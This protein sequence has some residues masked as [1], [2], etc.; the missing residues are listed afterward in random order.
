MITYWHLYLMASIYVL[1]GLNHFRSPKIYIKIMPPYL[2]FP[3]FLNALSGLVEIIFGVGL[4]FLQTQ[5]WASWGIILMLLSF[6]TVH[7]YMLTNSK[8]AMGL[9]KWVLILRIPLQFGLIY[10]AYQYT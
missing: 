4:F 9:P 10:W 3:K 5:K 7:F 2:K 8:A 6:L 1:A